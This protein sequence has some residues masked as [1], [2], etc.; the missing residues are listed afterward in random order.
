MAA[1]ADQKNVK[2]LTGLTDFQ[3]NR[4]MSM[5][6][7]SLGVHCD[8][9]HALKTGSGWDFPSDEKA[10]KIRAREMIR[11]VGDINRTAFD[12]K[13]VVSCYTCHRGS[14]Q[15]VSLVSLPQ[16][17]PPFP[18]P[19]PETPPLPDAKAIVARYAAALGDVSRLTQPRTMSGERITHNSRVVKSAAEPPSEE[20]R[21]PVDVV[22]DGTNVRVTFHDPKG[23]VD[24]VLLASGGWVRDREGV[25]VMP[26]NGVDN[27]RASIAAW[28]M[29]LPSSF[30]DAARTTGKERE[31]WIVTQG[32]ERFYFDAQ[33]GL[34]VRR[35]VLTEMP[36]GTMPQQTD[37]EDYRDVDGARVPFR[38]SAL[39]VDPW[40][41]AT[42]NY[43]SVKPGA[44][45]EG[46]FAMPAAAAGLP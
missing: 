13:P 22:D 33:S 28:R 46:Q 18:T 2:L 16:A 38:V 6:R 25:H 9:C 1:R 11:L 23:T 29:V 15:P 20:V 41:S 40:S 44:V 39:L 36:V 32:N 45:D 43:T 4:T 27:F 42:W 17:A 24:Q 3:L 21:L 37:Y 5:M 10:T 8:F 12:G 26:R 19:K 7:A 35:V 30:T 34:L 31:Q 14:I